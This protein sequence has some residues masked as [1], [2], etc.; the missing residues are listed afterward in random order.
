MWRRRQGG[1]YESAFKR[2][3][4][5]SGCLTIAAAF[6][7]SVA[8]FSEWSRPVLWLLGFA[9]GTFFAMWS[10]NVRGWR[11]YPV[12]DAVIDWNRVEEIATES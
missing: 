4:V 7:S 5:I 2:P 3:V 11:M 6:L 9:V 12:L 1:T 10:V 8:G